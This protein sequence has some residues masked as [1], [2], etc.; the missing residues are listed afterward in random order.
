MFNRNYNLFADT[1]KNTFH[2]LLNS[3]LFLLTYSVSLQYMQLGMFV[4]YMY[5]T[6]SVIYFIP[7]GACL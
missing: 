5:F 2:D 1:S 7:F 6:V 4:Y 3:V